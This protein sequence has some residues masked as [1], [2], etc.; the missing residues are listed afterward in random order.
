MQR[1]CLPRSKRPY[2]SNTKR[3]E[4]D[5]PFAFSSII[6]LQADLNTALGTRR[7]TSLQR[8]QEVG[9][10]V[11]GMSVKTSAQPLLVEEMGNQTDTSAEDEES[12]QD[13]H[14]EVVLG[15]LVGEGTAVAD[16]VNEADSNATVDVEDEVVLLRSSHGLDSKGVVEQLGAGEVLLD[17]LLDELDTEI[18]VV[19]GL[20]PVANTRD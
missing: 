3:P 5:I 11:P 19:A 1:P 18:R 20:D 14:L 8:G 17:V 12:V 2:W 13:T 4:P 16:K 7:T 10:V 9:D 6:T 15:L